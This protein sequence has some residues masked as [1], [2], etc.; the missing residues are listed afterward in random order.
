MYRDQKVSKCYSICLIVHFIT[1]SCTV[2]FFFF[3]KISIHEKKPYQKVS[4][5]EKCARF[6]NSID[7]YIS[8]NFNHKKYGVIVLIFSEMLKL[9]QKVRKKWDMQLQNTR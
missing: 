2:F 8:Y 1:D 5:I 6:L 7:K 3:S 9:Y 4:N